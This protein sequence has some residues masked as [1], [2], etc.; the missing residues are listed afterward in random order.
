MQPSLFENAAPDPER[1]RPSTQ[2]LVIRASVQGRPLG[3]HERA[4]NRALASV[5]RARARLDEEKRRL[6]R[7]LVHHA[8]DVRPRVDR[9]VALRTQI[10]RRL[11][12]FL[13]DTRLKSA[14]RSALAQILAEQLDDVLAHVEAPDADLQ[15]LF[16]R[17]HGVGYADA[18]QEQLDVLRSE[19]EEMLEEIGLDIEMPDLRPGMSEADVAAASAQ[20]AEEM[21]RHLEDSKA[22][23]PA[24][25]RQR[26]ADER[27]RR[28]EDMR[29]DSLGGVFRRLVKALH[30]DREA[31][32]AARGKKVNVMQDVTAA[33]KSGDLPT[34]LRLELEW[35]GGAGGGAS[36]LTEDKLRAYTEVL[37]AQANELEQECAAVRFHPRYAPLLVDTPF[38]VPL[39]IDGPGEVARLDAVIAILTTGVEQLTAGNVL[40]EVRGAIA[41]W[42]RRAGGQTPRRRKPRRRRR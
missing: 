20:M 36:Q 15:A 19:M 13:D 41:D 3:K 33:Y 25:K 38:G 34:L 27:A 9:A 23:R 7:A 12:P 31:D 32:P 18:A 8:A 24:S 22:G 2:D 37:K 39:V 4:Y 26:Q 16:E 17:L 10:V 42:R 6:E 21:R 14:D 11:A 1:S 40:Q 5:Q 30:P 29:K 28:F 35:I